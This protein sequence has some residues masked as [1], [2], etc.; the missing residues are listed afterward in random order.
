M[1]QLVLAHCLHHFG[2]VLRSYCCPR[3]EVNYGDVYRKRS[4][5]RRY[6]EHGHQG[7]HASQQDGDGDVGNHYPGRFKVRGEARHF[8]RL[9]RQGTLWM[10]RISR[11]VVH[12]PVYTIGE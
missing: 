6:Y 10:R 7:P 11:F 8:R 2:Y 12:E 3:E 5:H 9:T 4:S 1:R